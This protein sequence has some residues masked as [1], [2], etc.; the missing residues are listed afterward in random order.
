MT[1]TIDDTDLTSTDLARTDLASTDLTDTGLEGGTDLSGEQRAVL[2]RLFTEA[3]TAYT[4]SPEEVTDE[5]LRAAV[6]AAVHG[7][8]AFNIQPLRV[9]AIRDADARARLAAH[10]SSSNAPKTLAAPLTL[11]LAADAGFARTAETVFPPKPDLIHA[12]YDDPVAAAPVATMNATLQVGYLLIALRAAG[13]VVG[14]MTGGDLP[15]I[16]AEFFA[17]TDLHSLVVVNLGRAAADSH[18]SRN[19]RVDPGEVLRVL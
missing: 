11:V 16:D 1:S 18:R 19:P 15:A 12:L 6:E 2:R 14:P 13:L 9:L 8:T 3:H 17:G 4:W 7:P 10:L 5:V